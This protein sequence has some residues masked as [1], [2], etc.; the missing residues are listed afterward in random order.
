MCKINPEYAAHVWIDNGK[1]VLYLQIKKS[2]Y[3][4]ID[5]ALLWYKLYCSVLKDVV[6]VL[7]SYNMCIL[8]KLINGKQCTIACYIDDNKISHVK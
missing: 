8:N 2:I 6:S 5:S 7:N 1:Q 4:M 3:G